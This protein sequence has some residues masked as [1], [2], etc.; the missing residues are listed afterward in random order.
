FLAGRPVIPAYPPNQ[1]SL[2]DRARIDGIVQDA[3]PSVVLAPEQHTGM[4]EA[5]FLTVPGAEADGTNW[6]RP[7]G[8]ADQQVG[9]IQYTSGSTGNPRG[10]LVRHDSIAA[11]TAAIARAFGLSESSRG[12][13]WL[14]PYHDMGLIGGLLAPMSAGIP[15]RLMPPEDF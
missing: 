2:P 1:S 11:K 6:F 7:P 9:I 12:M 13:T 3:R 4:G 15:V 10:V 8:A 14:P 5:S